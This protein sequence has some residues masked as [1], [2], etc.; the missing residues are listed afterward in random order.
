MDIIF[1]C[2]NCDQ[3]LEVDATGAGSSI[4]C[5]SCAH[6][7]TVPASENNGEATETPRAAT[8][9][10]PTKVER[11]FSVPHHAGPTEALI[12]KASK[13]L[14]IAARESDRK[15]RVKTFKHTDCQE[16]GKDKFDEIVSNFLDKIG[17]DN[18]V[19]VTPITYSYVT[20]DTHAVVT[21][22]GVLIVFRG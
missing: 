20:M 9:A 6:T 12:Q 8:D 1:K 18:V 21:D 22:Y 2:P 3:E 5:P 11:H 16:V 7:I 13:P 10:A 4:E 15:V 19:S 14:E 17:W